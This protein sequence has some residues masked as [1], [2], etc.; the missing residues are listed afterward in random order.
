MLAE[1]FL[2]LSHAKVQR[3]QSQDRLKAPARRGFGKAAI[4]FSLGI[5]GISQD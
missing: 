3:A 1:N 2:T 5:S 4:F